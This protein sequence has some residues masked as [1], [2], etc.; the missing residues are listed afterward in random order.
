M[1]FLDTFDCRSTL[2]GDQSSKNDI[3][4]LKIIDGVTPAGGSKFKQT[5]EGP[6]LRF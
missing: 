2:Y 3:Y 6:L 1:I 4:W 5:L